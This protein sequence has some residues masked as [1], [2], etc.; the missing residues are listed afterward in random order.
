MKINTITMFNQHTCAWIPTVITW[1]NDFTEI[2]NTILYGF[3]L[4]FLKISIGFYL[5]FIS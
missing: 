4:K 2:N 3:E 5:K 1:K